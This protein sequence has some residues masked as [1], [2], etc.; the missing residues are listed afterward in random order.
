M[1]SQNVNYT[2]SWLRVGATVGY[3][4]T[5]DYESRVYGYERGPLYNYS[6]RSYDGEGIRYSLFARAD[7]GSALMLIAQLSTTDYF[8]RSQIS[9]GY[10]LIDRS[11]KTDLQ[12]QV[13]I[14]L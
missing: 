11:S 4:N 1:A 6:Y 2:L 8:D 12:L 13:R 7:I 5:D 14:R 3:F 9:S 10:Q